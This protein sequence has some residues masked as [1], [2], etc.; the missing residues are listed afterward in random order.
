MKKQYKEIH[1]ERLVLKTV[2]FASITVTFASI[3]LAPVIMIDNTNS[4]W[5]MIHFTEVI[6]LDSSIFLSQSVDAIPNKSLYESNFIEENKFNNLYEMYKIA[7]FCWD[8]LKFMSSILCPMFFHTSDMSAS[9][10]DL[11][12]SLGANYY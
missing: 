2:I 9:P 11:P 5:V 1:K 10:S 8:P 6:K 4:Y 12:L 3:I 7:T